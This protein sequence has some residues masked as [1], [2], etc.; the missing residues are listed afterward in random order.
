MRMFNQVCMAVCGTMVRMA[1][2]GVAVGES[3]LVGDLMWSDTFTIAGRCADGYYSPVGQNAESRV[4]H[5]YAL[6]RAAGGTQWRRPADFSFNTPT[7]AVAEYGGNSVGNDG[8]AGG[9]AQS[10]GGPNALA[11]FRGVLPSRVIFQTDARFTCNCLWIATCNSDI[12]M[13]A[14]SFIVKFPRYGTSAISIAVYGGA[15][16]PTGLTTG[17]ADANAA[18]HNYAVIFD[19]NAQR[20][21]VFVDE[22]SRGVVDLAGL[23]L[24]MKA[25]DSLI[26]FGYPG[27]VGWVDN[28]QAGVPTDGGSDLALEAWRTHRMDVP[29][30]SR[31]APILAD[32][33]VVK[34]GAG[35]LD[36]G[37]AA[38]ARGAVQVQE[39]TVAVDATNPGLPSQLLPGLVF[40]VDA[41]VNVTAV[42]G[43]VSVWRDVR[44]AAD[45][46]VY[47]RAVARGQGEENLEAPTLIDG[48]GTAAG[49]KLVDFG[50][51][52]GP[53]AGW[54][55]W[56]DADGHR[57][58]NDVRTVF[59]V[60]ECPNGGGCV[61]GDWNDADPTAHTGN[62]KWL[63]K[64]YANTTSLVDAY[65]CGYEQDGSEDAYVNDVMGRAADQKF[66]RE[67]TVYVRSKGRTFPCSTFMNDR[68]A[69]Q[70]EVADTN[71][72]VYAV[73][74]QGGGRLAEVL[75]YN[76]E[77][78]P[79]EIH[80]INAYLMRKWLNGMSLGDVQ[81]APGAALRVA[82]DAVHPPMLGRVTGAGRVEVTGTA[83]RVHLAAVENACVTTPFDL[84]PGT[85]VTA[86]ERV[87]VAGFPIAPQLGRAYAVTADGVTATAGTDAAAIVKTG[88]GTLVAS[89]LPTGRLQVAA[90]ALRL[91]GHADD[92]APA[93]N[94][95]SN[96]GFE[97]MQ[98]VTTD[99]IRGGNITWG[100]NS[101]LTNW[102][103]SS[104]SGVA[105]CPGSGFATA[106]K[107]ADG[108]LAAFMQSDGFAATSFTVP[109]AGWYR[110]DF[111]AFK[112]NQTS[113]PCGIFDV[114]LDDVPVCRFQVN[115][116]EPRAF[117][118]AFPNELAAGTHTLRFQ[119]VKMADLDTMA[120]LDNVRVTEDRARVGTNIVV[121][122]GFEM[123]DPLLETTPDHVHQPF[124]YA[125]T[126]ATWVFVDPNNT[127]VTN[128]GIAQ[129]ENAWAAWQ[130]PEGTCMAFLRQNGY[131]AQDLV[132]P[133]AGRYRLSFTMRGRIFSRAWNYAG[134]TFKVFLGETL[135]AYLQGSSTEPERVTVAL[136]AIDAA[137][138]AQRLSFRGQGDNKHDQT[139][140]FDDIRVERVPETLANPSFEWS[141]PFVNGTW[142][143]GL[144]GAGWTFDVG[145][146]ERNQSGICNRN[147]PWTQ[148]TGV[149]FGDACAFLQTKARIA[150]TITV[151]ED[152]VYCVSF[153]ARRRAPLYSNHDFRV[154]CDGMVLGAVTTRNEDDW[155]RFS[156]R[157]PFLKAGRPVELAFEGINHGD[158]IDRA[159]MID[160]VA[161]ERVAAGT[162][163]EADAFA[164]AT[165][166]LAAG[167]TLELDFDGTV[168]LAGLRY[169][170]H[171]R[172]GELNAAN[173]DFIRGAGT[174]YV[175]PTSTVI[176]LR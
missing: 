140:L 174:V 26:G 98:S 144:Q 110:I 43:K 116:L 59:Y 105:S 168:E 57:S 155:K 76:R 7:S 167:T 173:C 3:T 135:V 100:Y 151:P 50:T 172:T 20:V 25:D 162:E 11:L 154:V 63:P 24:A 137:H 88:N 14:N 19:R 83:G 5:V 93:A 61:L 164:G 49:R 175:Q 112:R 46:R 157:T 109:R 64:V 8:A 1:M 78:H 56:Q 111:F 95:V 126:G 70:G 52:G 101:V 108:V 77:L 139:T 123:H 138:L 55:Q 176:I 99:G 74:R 94:L 124:Q 115:T 54:L 81:F 9:F 90:G 29:V 107:T 15:D 92:E 69:R 131:F 47:P 71:G 91:A 118:T 150:Q 66:R 113:S 68:N 84:A 102:T 33:T 143:S 114:L 60:M 79:T 35:M 75:V 65:I 17:V 41:N 45:G 166:E 10:G 21:E 133:E 73:N 159:S 48:T 58:A 42:G 96:A 4:D 53:D 32:G 147:G 128:A 39:G 148:L 2:G 80:M 44:E 122:G 22:V 86:D 16:V 145:A 13:C 165:V 38:I 31:R 158:D 40:W 62:D 169:A 36:L 6:E 171:G 27:Y 82:A 121:N 30:A 136:P 28:V 129:M 89:A 18:W 72:T 161:I 119:G 152:G 127:S 87:R 130:A 153:S 132:F 125:P 117:G 142:E 103:F 37:G 141:G 146:N 104:L 85:S 97:D 160:E 170:G 149:P 34:T 134:Q 120:L 51:F 67:L 23:G 106:F 12:P 163:P 156:F